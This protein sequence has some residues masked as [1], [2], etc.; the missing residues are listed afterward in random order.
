MAKANRAMSSSISLER[1][2]RICHTLA[3]FMGY[4]IEPGACEACARCYYVMPECRWDGQHVPSFEDIHNAS[5]SV[6]DVYLAY[7]RHVRERAPTRAPLVPGP[8]TAGTGN[9]PAE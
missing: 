3:T 9:A 6:K 1:R 4:R 8:G 5:V 2:A 7:G